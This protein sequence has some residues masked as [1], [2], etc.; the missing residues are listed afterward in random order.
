[1][2]YIQGWG[3][4]T[5]TEKKKEKK[6]KYYWYLQLFNKDSKKNQWIGKRIKIRLFV[7]LK[8]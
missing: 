5:T 7:C 8:I 6:K 2:G 4:T 3:T 1:M